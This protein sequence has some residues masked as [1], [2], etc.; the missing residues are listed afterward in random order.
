MATWL[1]VRIRRKDVRNTRKD[2]R[3][4]RKDVR[5]TRKDVRVRVSF[6]IGFSYSCK[7]K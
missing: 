7:Y 6:S 3:N 5:N 2:V 1:E 4:K